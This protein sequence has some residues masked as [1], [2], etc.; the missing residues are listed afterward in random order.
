MNRTL[1]KKTLG[2]F[3]N[4][5]EVLLTES[6]LKER[7]KKRWSNLDSNRKLTGAKAYVFPC[8]LDLF[9]LSRN[10]GMRMLIRITL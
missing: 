4:T 1:L 2:K 9:F 10:T 3:I 5:L 7:V 8:R 6:F